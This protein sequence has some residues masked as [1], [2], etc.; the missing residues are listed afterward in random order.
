MSELYHEVVKPAA[1]IN[2]GSKQQCQALKCL[3][4]PADT[5]AGPGGVPL[6]LCP[7]H[8]EKLLG[9]GADA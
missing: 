7:D 6:T 3:N 4:R 9:V 8:R 5:V 1:P 2:N